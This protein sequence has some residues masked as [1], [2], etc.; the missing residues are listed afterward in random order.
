[1]KEWRF[2]VFL[3]ECIIIIIL[4][5]FVF[6]KFLFSLNEMSIMLN[7]IHDQIEMMYEMEKK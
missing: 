7:D 1:M 3:G 5:L 2:W 6:T 4:C